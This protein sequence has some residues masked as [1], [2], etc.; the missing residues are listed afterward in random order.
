MNRSLIRRCG[1]RAVLAGSALT[2]A[3]CSA[4]LARI[5]RATDQLLD[6]RSQ[7]IG[8]VAP[9]PARSLP[10]PADRRRLT[11]KTPTTINPATEELRLIPADENRSVAESLARYAEQ[12]IGSDGTDMMQ[13]TLPDALRQAQQT[14]REYRNAEESYILAAIALLIERHLWSP[15]LFN[16]TSAFVGADG[17]EGRFD[18]ELEV[19]NTLRVTQRLPSGGNVEARWIARATDQLRDNATQAYRSSSELVLSADIPLLRGAGSVAREDLIQ[20]ERSLVYGARTFERF[21]R[22]FLVDIADDFFSLVESRNRITNRE[23]QLESRVRADREA[24]AKV[25][26]GRLRPFQRDITA[27][28]AEE[29]RAALAQDREGYILQ[30]ERFKIRLGLDPETPVE[31]LDPDFDVPEPAATP[32]EA[33]L[34]ALE[35]RLDL[36][37]ERD[38]LVDAERGVKNARNELLPDLDI[39]ASVGFETDD[40]E[41]NGGFALDD[42]ELDYRVGIALG[43]PL[44]RRIERLRVRQSLIARDRS[45]REFT[46]FRDGI[47]VSARAAVRAVDLARFQLDLAERQIEINERGLED[48]RLR[49]DSDPQSIVDRENALLDAQ[50]ARDSALTDLRNAVL[51][52]LLETGQLRVREDGGFDAPPGVD[53]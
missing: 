38:R 11:E 15:R 37:N 20:S 48:L 40:D 19:V 12:A 16:D 42:D 47:V 13:L 27:N 28:A 7:S 30:L 43:L 36:Q 1:L 41:V 51:D 4:P 23:R 31:I 9:R 24:Q 22:F 50:N 32:E 33:T 17:D 8:T 35:Y 52:F 6:E 29:T 34:L 21:R 53:L 39:A 49:D 44:D 25:D 18:H 10:D 5:D 46:E 3:A 14:G 45:R 2:L 26:A